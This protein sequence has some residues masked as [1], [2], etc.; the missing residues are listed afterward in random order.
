[1]ISKTNIDFILGLVKEF[2]PSVLEEVGF[3]P[4]VKEP[5]HQFGESVEEKLVEKL[6]AF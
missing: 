6:K 3:D 4:N 5:G 1:M 2:L